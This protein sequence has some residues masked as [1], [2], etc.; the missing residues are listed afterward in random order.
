MT[1]MV[2]TPSLTYKGRTQATELMGAVGDTL[3]LDDEKLMDAVTA[4][5]GSGPAYFFLFMA[6]LVAAAMAQ[7]LSAD[8]AETLVLKTAM[9][10]SA[11]A[12]QSDAGLP[13]LIA[14]VTS[15]GGTTEAALAEFKKNEALQAVV[16][17]AVAA[18]VARAAQL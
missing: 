9:G 16:K 13:Q 2:A 17:K 4:I 5:S 3:W 14:Q 10:A 12:A 15:P 11:L 7:G 1:V 18:A 6:E 8:I